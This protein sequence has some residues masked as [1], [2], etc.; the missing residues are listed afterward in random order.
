M[1]AAD[2]PPHRTSDHAAWRPA[3]AS[4][5]L[6]VRWIQLHLSKCQAARISGSLENRDKM[7]PPPENQVKGD[8]IEADVRH[9]ADFVNA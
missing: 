7:Q 4:L 8:G 6:G 1:R 5:G 2:Q 9:G 3:D